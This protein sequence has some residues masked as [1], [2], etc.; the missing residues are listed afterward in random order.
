MFRHAIGAVKNYGELYHT[1]LIWNLKINASSNYLPNGTIETIISEKVPV[2][3]YILVAK[4]TYGT[5]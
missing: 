3:E 4:K 1:R 2:R 5:D